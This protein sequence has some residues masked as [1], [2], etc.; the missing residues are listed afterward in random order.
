MATPKSVIY[1]IAQYSIYDITLFHTNL[2][3]IMLLY[4]MLSEYTPHQGKNF[5]QFLKLNPSPQSPKGE[6]CSERWLWVFSVFILCYFCLYIYQS[7]S[8]KIF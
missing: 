7:V 2:T 5:L 4:M 1:C 3:I 6:A 8:D